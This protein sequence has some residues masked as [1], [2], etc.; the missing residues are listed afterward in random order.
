MSGFG[1][2]HAADLRLAI[3]EVLNQ[4]RREENDLILATRLERFGHTPGTQRLRDE[5]A[6]LAEQR[7]VELTALGSGAVMRAALTTK[8]VDVALGR[9]SVAGILRPD[10]S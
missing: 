3:L 8:G 10:P 2:L 7:C 1:Q 4:D 6:W 9:E 5:L